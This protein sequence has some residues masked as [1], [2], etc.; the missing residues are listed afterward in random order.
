MFCLS[1]ANMFGGNNENEWC[2]VCVVG[3]CPSDCF[4]C[5]SSEVLF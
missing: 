4:R 2:I 3:D 1:V 5:G